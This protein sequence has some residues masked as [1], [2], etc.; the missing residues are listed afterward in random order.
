MDELL[1]SSLDWELK[2]PIL[3][4]PGMAIAV[5]MFLFFRKKRLARIS[6]LPGCSPDWITLWGLH[7]SW[8]GFA[9][10]FLLS[11][12]WGVQLVAIGCLLDIFDGK[13]N[14]AMIEAGIV[15]SALDRWIGKWLDPLADKL[16][17]LPPLIIFCALGGIKLWVVLIVVLPELYGIIFREP[18]TTIP[19]L[20][21]YPRDMPF[22]DRLRAEAAK[23]P[24]QE[25]RASWIGKI[26]TMVRDFGLLAFVPFYLH[27][28][29]APLVAD[30]VFLASVPFGILSIISRKFK[31]A[32]LKRSSA[33]A[34]PYFKHEDVL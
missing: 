20:L 17:N 12:Y 10:F 31:F 18:I 32:W 29:D 33:H 7:F 19:A 26:K 2:L 27:W 14:A 16:R 15:R 1:I 24:P 25:S 4:A 22:M 28:K 23:S 3:L 8:A 30:Y 13:M 11:P 21:R 9:V 34:D 5:F 6:R